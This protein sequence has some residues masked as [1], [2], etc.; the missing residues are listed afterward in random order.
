MQKHTMS[1]RQA[2][3]NG[4]E[5]D[6][7]LLRKSQD[8]AALKAYLSGLEGDFTVRGVTLD[9]DICSGDDLTFGA[10][11]AASMSFELTNWNNEYTDFPWGRFVAYGAVKTGTKSF[12]AKT[13]MVSYA[14]IGTTW[15][16]GMNDGSLIV[17]Y[18]DTSGQVPVRTEVTFSTGTYPVVALIADQMNPIGPAVMTV[19]Y[20]ASTNTGSTG[21]L[22]LNPFEWVSSQ[23]EDNLNRKMCEKYKKGLSVSFQYDD[24]SAQFD[25]V[26]Y[27]W[28]KYDVSTTVATV[29]ELAYLG[30]YVINKPDELQ[31]EILVFNNVHNVFY[32]LDIDASD[33]QTYLSSPKTIDQLSEHIAL[34]VMA[35][36][37]GI[38]DY[39]GFTT[40]TVN[41]GTFGE[42]CSYTY[43]EILGQCAEYF[44]CV[45]ALRAFGDKDVAMPSLGAFAFVPVCSSKS[46]PDETI[47]YSNIVAGS[48]SVK[49]FETG[50]IKD[51]QILASDGNKAT[52]SISVSGDQTYQINASPITIDP[53]SGAIRTGDMP[54]R[55]GTN[56]FSFRPASFAIIQADPGVELG[57]MI[58]VYISEASTQPEVDVWGKPT[59]QTQN[60]DPIIMPLMHRTLTWQGRWSAEY[61]STGSQLREVDT[62]KGVYGASTAM[63]YTDSQISKMKERTTLNPTYETN[64]YVS[65][66]AV[67]RI[68]IDTIGEE[69]GI[70]NLNLDIDSATLP[71]ND[72]WVKIAEFAHTFPRK[73]YADISAQSGGY[74]L[75]VE[76]DTTGELW[77]YNGSGGSI[78]GWCR[79][80]IPLLL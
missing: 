21:W 79:A 27:T 78:S 66:T 42:N 1:Y 24:S 57:D 3:L 71:S 74:T 65:S 36:Y 52:Y 54:Y 28:T 72:T 15:I 45:A 76:L 40:D 18:N 35:E 49:S 63:A 62:D 9:E 14:E 53:M 19:S 44:G 80:V 39:S 48:L 50:L 59:G 31:N 16:Y 4:A 33:I 58:R 51:L 38:Y 47:Q 77:I 70:L 32:Q 69:S 13:G 37:L 55:L 20:N 8:D 12:A 75:L 67:A 6:V 73:T 34:M 60:I 22:Y 23:P 2:L 29:Y 56:G 68:S 17:S 10:I 11:P 61:Q 30:Q 43:R 64:S 46:N 41:A 26:I 5:Q 25:G 7:L